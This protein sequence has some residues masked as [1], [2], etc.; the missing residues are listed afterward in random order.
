MRDIGSA[1]P[2]DPASNGGEAGF[3]L[4]EVIVAFA[5]L[6]ITLG[7]LFPAISSSIGRTAQSDSITQARLLAQSLLAQVGRDIPA[8]PGEKAG[9]DDHGHRWRLRQKLYLGED[10]NDR[11]STSLVEVSAEVTWGQ[12]KGE[13]DGEPA[14]SLTI[15]TL[16]LAPR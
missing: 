9:E 11:R 12:G 6:A 7:V 8:A 16:R 14:R 15:T 5:I 10:P 3:T 2:H 4:V 1:L 13:G